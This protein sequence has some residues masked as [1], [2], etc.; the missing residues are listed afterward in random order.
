MGN[1]RKATRPDLNLAHDELHQRVAEL[2]AEGLEVDDWT[3]EPAADYAPGVAAWIMAKLDDDRVN[4][5]HCDTCD[6]V[7]ITIDK[8]PGVTPAFVSHGMLGAECEGNTTS[9]WYRV[10][11]EWAI[12]ATHEWYRPSKDELANLGG[13]TGPLVAE[14]EHVA[15]GGLMLRRIPEDSQ[16]REES[17]LRLDMPRTNQLRLE[18]RGRRVG[19]TRRLAAVAAAEE[20][21]KRRGTGGYRG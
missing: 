3:D 7:V 2:A 12:Y 20:Q 17:L 14:R 18:V 4:A 9:A 1:R 19:Q 21:N 10:R 15:A 8:H 5:Y 6:Q 11:Q 13:T 16:T